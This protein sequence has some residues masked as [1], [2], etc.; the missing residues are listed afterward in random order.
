MATGLPIT[1]DQVEIR[2]ASVEVR[3]LTLTRKQVTLSVFRQLP[4]RDP[5]DWETGTLRGEVW[6]WVNYLTDHGQDVW[7]SR[8]TLWRYAH[9][10]DWEYDNG[11][12]SYSWNLRETTHDKYRVALARIVF[13][14][15]SNGEP[16]CAKDCT[17]RGSDRPPH[18]HFKGR[19]F[20]LSKDS[21]QN[22]F[23]VRYHR[24]GWTVEKW[25][26]QTPIGT[27]EWSVK[28]DVMELDFEDAGPTV[29]NYPTRLAAL[30]GDAAQRARS[31]IESA[32]VISRAP[33]L[34]IAV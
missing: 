23:L 14:S 30:K 10:A 34:F 24:D 5:I 22:D 32:Q 2:T 27:F 16:P 29:A 15:C 9:R 31:V 26:D 6:G 18:I 25:F 17:A 12:E 3:T 4:E 19:M 13:E 20:N 7:V 11:A 1:V 28:P 8:H 33:Q 21:F